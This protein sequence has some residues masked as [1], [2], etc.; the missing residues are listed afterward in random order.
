MGKLPQSLAAGLLVLAATTGALAATELTAPIKEYD[1]PT[2][3][4]HPH[5]PAPDGV[6]FDIR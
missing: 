4:A 6:Q 5:D 2:K 3:D 1:V